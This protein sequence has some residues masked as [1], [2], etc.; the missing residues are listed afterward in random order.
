MGRTNHPHMLRLSTSILVFFLLF[1]PAVPSDNASATG[2]GTPE[3]VSDGSVSKIHVGPGNSTKGLTLVAPYDTKDVYLVDHNGHVV[4]R[5]ISDRKTRGTAV[6]LDNGNLLRVRSNTG[7]SADGLHILGLDGSVLWDWDTPSDFDLHHDLEPMPNGN[8]LINAVVD[9]G[10][11]DAIALGRDPDLIPNQ[12]RVE[13]IVEIQPN[14][15]TGG[16]VVWMWDPVDHLIQDFDANKP[17]YGVVDDHPELI[18]VNFPDVYSSEWQ[19]SNSVAYNPELDQVMITNRNFDEFWII[20][21]NT[22]IA[23]AAGHSGGGQG[24]GGDVLYRWGNPGSYGASNASNHILYGPHDAH[25]IGHGLPGEGNVLIFNNGNNLFMTRPEGRIST[26][27]E[28]SPPVNGSG[29]YDLVPGT[30]FGPGDSVWRYS[31]NPPEDFFVWSMGNAQRLPNGNTMI[32]GGST[33]V[34]LEIDDDNEVVWEYQT[35]G[36]FKANRY[37]PPALKQVPGIYA[38]EDVPLRV[39]ISPYISDLDTDVSGLVLEVDDPYVNVSGHELVLLYPDGVAGNVLN[40]SVSDGIFEVSRDVQVHVTPVN[41]PPVLAPI[42]DISAV[43]AIPYNL[44]LRKYITDPDTPVEAMNI[45]VDS[46]FVTVERASLRFLYPEGVLTDRVGVSV[47]DGEFEDRNEILVNITPVDYPP[48]VGHIQDQRGLEDVPWTIDLGTYIQ[49]ISLASSSRHTT[50]SGMNLTLLYPEGVTSDVVSLT[51]SDGVNKAVVE[52][53][54]TI[55]PVNDP[56]GIDELPPLTVR[57][58]ETYSMDVGPYIRDVDTPEEELILWIDSPVAE[59]QGHVIF[60]LYPEGGL[61]DVL[62]VEVWDGELGSTTELVVT[63]EPV[64][65]APDIDN[66][67]PVTVKEDVPTTLDLGPI[68]IDVDTPLENLTL[69]VDSP[70]VTA[71]G[72]TLVLLYPDG[73]LADQVVVE[74]WDGELHDSTR[75]VVSVEPV[76][77]PPWWAD[78]P[79]LAAIEDVEGELDLGLYMNDVDTPLDE[80]SVEADSAHGSVQGQIF[81]YIYPEGVLAEQVTFTLSDGEYQSV[82]VMNVAV[83]PVNDAPELTVVKADPEGKSSNRY[84]FIVIYKDVDVGS[85]PPVVEVVVNDAIY[86]CELDEEAG[87]SYDEGIVYYAKVDMR[88]GVNTFYF[89]ADDGN[90]GTAT[91]EPLSVDVEKTQDAE[92]I[93]PMTVVLLVIVLGAVSLTAILLARRRRSSRPSG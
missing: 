31:E 46:P 49:E 56:P 87:G 7:G 76:N 78:I 68:V 2:P 81:S 86:E 63:V 27:E 59:V 15:T 74:V 43:E 62:Q 91:T 66:I 35:D 51:I 12:L 50:I 17:N 58:E 79:D 16:D 60:L 11:S 45:Q 8:V 1:H 32:G 53:T 75:L 4:H 61:T 57:E 71:E 29:G 82:L 85:A 72:L 69:Q 93:G 39:D 18:D 36:I 25:W 5:W 38:T 22:T 44:N 10:L 9:Y 64:N 67:P 24:K 83:S 89:N 84:K 73:I 48:I 28:M 41:D 14:G 54:V 70:F 92:G 42:P 88:P 23:E 20:D 26:I 6:L 34:I 77:D 37:Y 3:P 13:P 55:E 65:D 21:H 30:A 47:S 19:H 80:L 33:G 40:L 52:F 90:G